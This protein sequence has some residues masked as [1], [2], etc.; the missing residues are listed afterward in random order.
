MIMR[1]F[2]LHILCLLLV[3]IPGVQAQMSRARTD[4]NIFGHVVAEGKHLP[5]ATVTVRGT[6]IGTATDATGHYRLL[7]LPEKEITIVA[8]CV[9]YKPQSKTVTML[10]NETVEVNFELEVDLL[11]VEQVVVTADRSAVARQKSSTIINT[12]SPKLLATTNARTISEG[13]PFIPGLRMENNCQNCGFNQVRLNGMEGAYSQILVDGHA[14]F[15]GL[16]G[17]YGM[18]LIPSNM[19]DRIEIQRG[20][21]STLYGSNAVAGTVN[22]ILQDPA[23]DAFEAGFSTAFAGVGLDSITGIAPDYNVSFNASTITADNRTGL[24]VYGNHRYRTPLDVNG[25]TIS[26]YPR[27][28]NTTLGARLFHR[29]GYRGKLTASYFH[30]DE[31]RRGGDA[32][33]LPVHEARVAEAPEHHVNTAS[34]VYTQMLRAEDR[35]N[36][37]FSMSHIHRDSYY[38]GKS[39]KD[40]GLTRDLTYSTGA[41]YQAFMGRHTLTSGFDVTGENLKDQKPGYTDFENAPH[42]GGK[43][44]VENAPF[45]K[46]LTVADQRTWTAGLFSQY[47]VQLGIA[48][49]TAGLRLDH[50]TVRDRE[51]KRNIHSAFVPVPRASVLL[52]LRHDLQMRLN[53]AMGYRAPQLYNEELHVGVAGAKRIVQ[54]ISNDLKRETS[55]SGML[56]FDFNRQFDHLALGV[57]VEGFYTH[58]MNAFIND[59]QEETPDH[60]VVL[61]RGNHAPGAR[62]FGVNLEVNLSPMRSLA[63]KVGGTFQKNKYLGEV[64]GSV[65]QGEANFLRT[66]DVYGFL[67]S[68]WKMWKGLS[69]SASFNLTGPM[70]VVYEGKS[71]RNDEEKRKLAADNFSIRRTPWFADLGLKLN[72]EF[73][74]KSATLNLF[75]GAKNIFNS[76]QKDFDHGPERASSYVYGPMLPR[77][78]YVGVKL[79]NIL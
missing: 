17:V 51:V 14:I 30:I 8:S 27:L 46:T 61:E 43:V 53:Y 52:N 79:G 5:Y 66:P 59:R 72:Y 68:D 71:W 24:A 65:N 12:V 25:D 73:Q 4:A 7:N 22:I 2:A 36:V 50:Y 55:H 9:G 74:V 13:L 54:R 67:M 28:R 56:S 76:Y 31:Q 39:L 29:L 40:Y 19:V 60:V 26:E 3:C 37:N 34:L 49:L 23:V 48:T 15:S 45:V 16:M 33:D 78:L 69:L 6:T 62:I 64:P 41:Q 10:P 21:G 11:N 42:G 35:L 1:A 44:D 38:G 58:L 75:A 32:F 77:T 18:E 63:F 57:L 70:S 47:S 20:G